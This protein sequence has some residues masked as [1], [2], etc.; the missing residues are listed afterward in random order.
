VNT[1]QLLAAH[2]LIDPNLGFTE[3]ANSPDGCFTRKSCLVAACSKLLEAKKQVKLTSERQDAMK[4]WADACQVV[5]LLCTHHKI[6]MEFGQHTRD[7]SAAPGAPSD[8]R[9]SP[10]HNL[11][12]QCDETGYMVLDAALLFVLSGAKLDGEMVEL[13]DNL[14]NSNRAKDGENDVP[15]PRVYLPFGEEYDVDDVYNEMPIPAAIKWGWEV[16]NS[17]TAWRWKSHHILWEVGWRPESHAYFPLPFKMA[18]EHLVLLAKRMGRYTRDKDTQCKA[19]IALDLEGKKFENLEKKEFLF[20]VKRKDALKLIGQSEISNPNNKMEVTVKGSMVA[21]NTLHD[22][23]TPLSFQLDEGKGTGYTCREVSIISSAKHVSIRGAFKPSSAEGEGDNSEGEREDIVLR[24]WNWNKC[25]WS[26]TSIVLAEIVGEEEG[27]V[28]GQ[29]PDEEVTL[30]YLI[31][32]DE[33]LPDAG[34]FVFYCPGDSLKRFDGGAKMMSTLATEDNGKWLEAMAMRERMLTKGLEDLKRVQKEQKR[35]RKTNAH[36]TAMAATAIAVS[37]KEAELEKQEQEKFIYKFQVDMRLVEEVEEDDQTEEEMYEAAA[38]KKKEADELKKEAVEARA[39]LL[40]KEVVASEA[41]PADEQNAEVPESEEV[42][43]ARADAEEKAAIATAAHDEARMLATKA[44][45]EDLRQQRELRKEAM[46]LAKVLWAKAYKDPV[47][48]QRAGERLAHQRFLTTHKAKSANTAR[49]RSEKFSEDLRANLEGYFGIGYRKHINSVDNQILRAKT[50]GT[51]ADVEALKKERAGIV[52]HFFG[53]AFAGVSTPGSFYFC[54]LVYTL[55]YRAAAVS[56]TNAVT[57]AMG[58]YLG[59]MEENLERTKQREGV[60]VGEAD[61]EL[62][63]PTG[64]QPT[65]DE[66]GEPEDPAAFEERQMQAARAARIAEME[67]EEGEERTVMADE[68]SGLIA[69]QSETAWA[70]WER[71]FLE[72]QRKQTAEADLNVKEGD[73]AAAESEPRHSKPQELRRALQ[74]KTFA[75]AAEARAIANLDRSKEL[76]SIF[77]SGLGFSK[78]V[79]AMEVLETGQAAVVLPTRLKQPLVVQEPSNDDDEEEEPEEEDED[80]EADLPP[81]VESTELSSAGFRRRM[82]FCEEFWQRCLGSCHAKLMSML[83]LAKDRGDEQAAEVFE[84]KALQMVV[85]FLQHVLGTVVQRQLADLYASQARILK[86]IKRAD[87][88]TKLLGKLAEVKANWR[89]GNGLGLSTKPSILQKLIDAVTGVVG[90]EVMNHV[91]LGEVKVLEERAAAAKLHL[92][93]LQA[94]I[95]SLKCKWAT[96]GDA[97]QG[98]ATSVAVYTRVTVTMPM[99]EPVE[100]AENDEA[101]EEEARLSPEEARL[102]PEQKEDLLT[103][104]NHQAEV[105]DSKRLKSHLKKMIAQLINQAGRVDMKRRRSESKGRGSVNLDKDAVVLAANQIEQTQGKIISALEE[106]QNDLG[107]LEQCLGMHADKTNVIIE[108]Q[109]ESSSR[110]QELMELIVSGAVQTFAVDNPWTKPSG[111]MVVDLPKAPSILGDGLFYT[112]SKR[113]AQYFVD[114]QQKEEE[115]EEEEEKAALQAKADTEAAAL[116]EDDEQPKIDES[117]A[118]AGEATEGGY[119]DGLKQ[120]L[121]EFRA[122]FPVVTPACCKHPQFK[123]FV[124]APVALDGPSLPLTGTSAKVMGLLLPARVLIGVGPEG[125]GVAE[126]P[127]E[128]WGLLIDPA[129]TNGGQNRSAEEGDG[130][131]DTDAGEG[132]SFAEMFAKEDKEVPKEPSCADCLKLIKWWPWPVLAHVAHRSHQIPRLPLMFSK[133]SADFLHVCVGGKVPP[134][135]AMKGPNVMGLPDFI[136]ISWGAGFQGGATQFSQSANGVHPLPV[137]QYRIQ[138]RYDDASEA[139]LALRSNDPAS[140]PICYMSADCTNIHGTEDFKW[141]STCVE[142]PLYPGEAYSFR[143]SAMNQIGWSEWSVWSESAALVPLHEL[144]T[145]QRWLEPCGLKLPVRIVATVMQFLSCDDFPYATKTVPLI[146]DEVCGRTISID[147]V[148]VKICG[149]A[150]KRLKRW[151][152]EGPFP[153]TGAEVGRQVRAAKAE[154]SRVERMLAENAAQK[155]MKDQT[156]KRGNSNDAMHIEDDPAKGAIVPLFNS[157]NKAYSSSTAFCKAPRS[158]PLSLTTTFA[159]TKVKASSSGTM[160]ASSSSSSSGTMAQYNPKPSPT[161]KNKAMQAEKPLQFSDSFWAF[162]GNSFFKAGGSW[163]G[164]AGT[165]IHPAKIGDKVFLMQEAGHGFSVICG[166]EPLN[167]SH[168]DR[169][170]GMATVQ[171]KHSDGSI[172]LQLHFQE[173]GNASGWL[174]RYKPYVAVYDPAR[175]CEMWMPRALTSEQL[176]IWW[177]AR[178]SRFKAQEGVRLR[179]AISK[180]AIGSVVRVDKGDFSVRRAGGEVIHNR[181][182]NGAVLAVNRDGTYYVGDMHSNISCTSVFEREMSELLSKE[183]ANSQLAKLPE[184]FVTALR[185]RAAMLARSAKKLESGVNNTM[186]ASKI[187]NQVSFRF[188]ILNLAKLQLCQCCENLNTT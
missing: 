104:L 149:I 64:M 166:R 182:F 124:G 165:P 169:K 31:E 128:M 20:K 102:S 33:G 176:G 111:R 23:S 38:L 174:V 151:F 183:E 52:Q 107:E 171:G 63:L 99:A 126:L 27:P 34:E 112:Y 117:E 97:D 179:N 87:K 73:R 76:A 142:G 59:W 14:L 36:K 173:F 163:C 186:L 41:M 8:V 72:N 71:L 153:D 129:N 75:E 56:S 92:P 122:S 69:T 95:E 37:K 94:K 48:K 119:P 43:A 115:K 114:A 29:P 158:R 25:S 13:M 86:G 12:L 82:K 118:S 32:D 40:A 65:V 148:R 74:A 30:R 187:R 156:A 131:G 88:N 85:L 70:V 159:Q 2:P 50:Q 139:V 167:L 46:E 18:T 127:H 22:N 123:Q 162:L 141:K 170:W 103:V 116:A 15:L 93:K 7:S 42:A 81:A 21:G 89:H 5:H 177:K 125:M 113:Q 3:W 180:F 178:W 9:V 83:T 185:N 161:K 45:Q 35:E 144:E 26:E 108:L 172:D 28:P 184:H 136:R 135:P 19:L 60:L 10:L 84:A 68:M 188:R 61:G 67:K 101:E 106:A 146:I 138:R 54:Q 105:T 130:D 77:W 110:V 150:F 4:K 98:G 143:V 168:D 57:T 160:V 47:A 157:R 39:V 53:V 96:R 155:W 44:W 100:G 58:A 137:T 181:P 66:D 55:D 24:E 51:D 62:E 11:L 134:V 1:I 132:Y 121:S 78:I 17:V 145:E 133:F 79:Q 49:E 90:D 120:A 175:K 147:D 164:F 140:Y 109:A 91:C 6:D 16:S 80:D 154:S 152:M